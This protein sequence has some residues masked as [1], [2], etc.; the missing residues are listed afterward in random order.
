MWL[1][2]SYTN[3]QLYHLKLYNLYIYINVF[4]FLFVNCSLQKTLNMTRGGPA[5]FMFQV[6]KY[7]DSN[8]LD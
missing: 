7:Q 8:H 6:K 5:Y 2:L 3:A 4:S 1:I